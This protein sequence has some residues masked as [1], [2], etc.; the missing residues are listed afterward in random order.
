MSKEDFDL[1]E[2]E[3]AIHQI[4]SR[5]RSA[6]LLSWFLQSVWRME[7]EDVD[8]AICDGAGDKGIDALVVDDDLR[9]ITILQSKHRGKPDSEQ[10]DQDLRN[11]VGAA[12]YFESPE[13]VDGLIRSKPNAELLNLLTRLKIR[14]RVAEGAHAKRLVFVTNGLLDR[15][16]SDYVKSLADRQ[17]PLDVWDAPRLASVAGRTRR[18][19][20]RPDKV[21]LVSVMPPAIVDLGAGVTMAVGLV[22]ALELVKLDGIEDLSLFDRNVRLGVG[23]TRIN[24]QI[25]DTVMDAAEHRLFPAYHN[26]LTL[27]TYRLDIRKGRLILDG[28]T[29]VNGCQSMLALYRNRAKLSG[30]LTVLVKVVQVDPRGETSDK[31]TYRTNNQNPVDIRDQRS[32]DLVQRDLQ[33]QVNRDYEGELAFAIRAGEVFPRIPRVL[34]NQRAAQLLMAVYVGEPWNAVRKV[35]LFDEDYRRIFN[36]EVNSHRLYLMSVLDEVLDTA[37]DKLRPDLRASLAS[38]RLTLAYVLAQLLRESDRGRQLLAKPERWL[39]EL[40]GA[41][42]EALGSQAASVIDLVNGYIEEQ[43]K[44][45]DDTFDPKIVFKNEGE[46]LKVER[47]VMSFS[48]RL[49]AKDPSYKFDIPPAR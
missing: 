41:V 6:A 47:D 32:T 39:P 16:G 46:I 44:E 30:E 29:V 34:D 3:I 40:K 9:E 18:P 1:I 20:L 42:M 17:P 4:G 15:A 5:T 23:K 35:R 38:V 49:V 37:S 14:D 28:I 22:P 48:R 31:I 24:N 45:R 26:G 19:E 25:G 43:L 33:T 2:A 10:G 36:R 21:E 13:A 7:P 12:A 8:D 27:L 11:L